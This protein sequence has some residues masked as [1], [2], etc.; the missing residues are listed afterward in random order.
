MEKNISKIKHRIMLYAEYKHLS[1]RK[2]YIET[3]LS[4]GILDK[5]TGLTENNI[6][7]FISTYPEVNILWLMTREGEMIKKTDIVNDSPSSYQGINEDKERIKELKQHILTQNK[8]IEMLEG[9]EKQ[10]NKKE[11]CMKL[12]YINPKFRRL[13][14]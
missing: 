12:V 3:G 8:Y 13:K 2:I 4:N 5:K 9:S 1:K 6:E 14:Y 10:S 7:K 11:N